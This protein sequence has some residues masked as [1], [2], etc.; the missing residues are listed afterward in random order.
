[1]HVCAVELN[2]LERV[3]VLHSHINVELSDDDV[4]WPEFARIGSSIDYVFFTNVANGF[5]NVWLDTFRCDTGVELSVIKSVDKITCF[6]KFGLIT[7]SHFVKDRIIE[8]DILLGVVDGIEVVVE[9]AVRFIQD[10]E[11]DA[12][13]TLRCLMIV[14]V[15]IEVIP[16]IEELL[17]FKFAFLREADLVLND[18]CSFHDDIVVERTVSYIHLVRVSPQVIELVDI[19]SV[20]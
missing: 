4:F 13:M 20:A 3:P 2:F 12:L 17:H 14:A 18:S 11:Q 9:D 7:N 1:M 8:L 16:R 15:I 10:V 19:N 5:G 6:L